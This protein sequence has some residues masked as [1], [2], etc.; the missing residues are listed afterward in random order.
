MSKTLNMV[1]GGSSGGLYASIFATGV[2]QE[3]TV[4]LT[5]PNGKVKSGKWASRTASVDCSVPVMN[6]YNSPSG[7]VVE[8]DHYD[9][10]YGWQ[11]FDNDASTS[12]C[13][14]KLSAYVYYDFGKDTIIKN[15]EIQKPDNTLYRPTS[16]EIITVDDD[17]N[18]TPIQSYTF[19][20]TIG[21]Q[22]FTVDT[23]VVSKKWGIRVTGCTHFNFHIY[24]FQMFGIQ[25]LEV[26]G[27]LFDR[28]DEHGTYTLTANNGTQTVAKTVLVDVVED[29]IEIDYSGGYA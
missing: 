28:L 25:N 13:S 6:G 23:E 4:A 9:T 5:T 10:N 22:K 24:H 8:S 2:A 11:L 20:G 12:W 19:E 27:F 26:Y 14:A 18:V 17:G 29:R 21:L 15:F 16:F 3:D 7:Q 1:G